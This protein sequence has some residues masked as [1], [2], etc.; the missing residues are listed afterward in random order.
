MIKRAG[1]GLYIVPD[2]VNVSGG[3][4]LF[5]GQT[6]RN[7]GPADLG[8]SLRRDPPDQ[9]VIADIYTDSQ[10]VI[11]GLEQW[12]PSWKARGWQ[13]ADRKPVK[14]RDLWERLDQLR[15]EHQLTWHWVKGHSGHPGNTRA[16]AL[17]NEGVRLV[18]SSTDWLC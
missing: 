9:P 15:A 10:Y 16:D 6:V 11:K 17:A 3:R 1:Q 4:P 2:H 8:P 18:A 12:L 5:A 13:T 7:Q 14:N